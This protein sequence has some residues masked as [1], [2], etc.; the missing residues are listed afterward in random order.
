MSV[1]LK[2]SNPISETPS[3]MLT[4]FK[5]LQTQKENAF[6]CLILWGKVISHKFSQLLKTPKPISV[7]EGGS[8]ILIRLLHLL[9]LFFILRLLKN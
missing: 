2:A 3:G 7:I 8:S 9:I 6:I 4:S 5:L 1:E